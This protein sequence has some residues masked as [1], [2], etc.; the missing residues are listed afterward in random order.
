M[1][2]YNVIDYGVTADVEQLQTI[3]I[4][5]VLDMAGDNGGVVLFPSG[6]YRTG[7]VQIH[8]VLAKQLDTGAGLPGGENCLD[9]GAGAR[10]EDFIT[11]K[12]L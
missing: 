8:G 12:N 10:T 2:I 9:F 7:G 3:I 4:Q 11:G 5:R 6:V 1:S